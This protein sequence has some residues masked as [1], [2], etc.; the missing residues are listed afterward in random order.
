MTTATD[1]TRGTAKLL[2]NFAVKAIEA[3]SVSITF[4]AIP[5]DDTKEDE[6]AGPKW[7]KPT[8]AAMSRLPWD[9]SNIPDG[10]TAPQPKAAAE[11]LWLLVGTL[12]NNTIPPTSIGPTWKG[13]VTAEWHANGFD[14][15]IECDPEGNKTY[16][17]NGPEIEEYEGPI[18]DNL[19]QLQQHFRMLPDNGEL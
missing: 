11:L 12:D 3:R 18:E 13:G 2:E 9:E 1:E 10:G 15:E 8:I 19:T 6:T 5:G 17:F 14:L 7:L 16:Y 4:T